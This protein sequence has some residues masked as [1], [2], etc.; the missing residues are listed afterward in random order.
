MHDFFHLQFVRSFV[1]S[2]VA[3]GLRETE[4]SCSTWPGMFMWVQQST[5]L[6]LREKRKNEFKNWN[7]EKLLYWA[8]FYVNNFLIWHALFLYFIPSQFLFF[9]FLIS[10]PLCMSKNFTHTHT[11]TLSTHIVA[12]QKVICFFSPSFFHPF[13]FFY[14][15]SHLQDEYIKYGNAT[16]F[17]S[18]MFFRQPP[19]HTASLPQPNSWNA[20]SIRKKNFLNIVC[21]SKCDEFSSGIDGKALLLPHEMHIT[22]YTCSTDCLCNCFC[23]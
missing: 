6:H 19:L 14:T 11:F 7:R 21:N 20:I 12:K 18:R 15:L 3:V 4:N 1:H 16:H 13:Y 10:S 8:L 22:Y 5:K 23:Y 2:T 9:Q 17:L